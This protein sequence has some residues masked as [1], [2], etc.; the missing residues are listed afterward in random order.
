MKKKEIFCM[1]YPMI[2]AGMTI[3]ACLCITNGNG[4]RIDDRQAHYSQAG[5][6]PDSMRLFLDSDVLDSIL[7]YQYNNKQSNLFESNE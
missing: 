6:L 5:C 2:I 4:A 1:V 7:E 3:F